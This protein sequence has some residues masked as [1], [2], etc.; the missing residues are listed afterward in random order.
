EGG[1]SGCWRRPRLIPGRGR[2]WGRSRAGHEDYGRER[3]GT[4]DDGVTKK[5]SAS[6]DAAPRTLHA[7]RLETD[8]ELVCRAG[9]RGLLR[10]SSALGRN[11]PRSADRGGALRSEERRVG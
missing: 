7:S 5:Q 1:R 10:E 2:W 11:A 4:R 8:A 9:D 3:E 6:H